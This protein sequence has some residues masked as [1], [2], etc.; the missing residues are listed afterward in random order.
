MVNG[1][2]HDGRMERR[3]KQNGNGNGNENGNG[4]GNET[5][6]ARMAHRGGRLCVAAA[7][8]KLPLHG[9]EHGAPA[10]PTATVAATLGAAVG[11]PH[12]SPPIK[13]TAR[14]LVAFRVALRAQCIRLSARASFSHRSV[15]SDLLPSASL[16]A[17]L[18]SLCSCVRR[19]L[20][21]FVRAC[22]Y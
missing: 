21:A 15:Y 16:V 6:S 8:E 12:T 7:G 14:P 9:A 4:N 20:D 13:Y 5:Y 10:E 22:E 2:A 11:V 19:S 1:S 18:T 3:S 17:T